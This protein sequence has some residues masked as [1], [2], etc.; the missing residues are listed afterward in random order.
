[1][2]DTTHPSGNWLPTETWFE[3]ATRAAAIG[4]WEWD[5]LS[6][7]MRYSSVAR[8]ICGFERHE[9]ITYEMVR[10]VTH[11]DD[12]PWT[13]ERARRALDPAIRD[14]PEYEY[15]IVQRG[16]GA[17]RWV[18]ARGEAMF[19]TV[20]GAERATRYVG[21]IQD[22]TEERAIAQ[23]LADSEARLRLAVE[24]AGMAV[25]E[26]D[27]IRGTLTRSPELNRLFGF[28]EDAEPTLDEF[29]SRYAPGE[30]QRIEAESAEVIA[31]G[32]DRIQTVIKLLWPDGTP[33]WLL[34]LAQAVP[35]TDLAERRAIGVVM[36]VTRQKLQEERLETVAHEMHHRIKNLIAIVGAIASQSL[37]GAPDTET[38]LDVLRGRLKALSLATD[39]I[40]IRGHAAGDLSTL[41]EAVIEPFRFGEAGR[42]VV[43]GDPAEVPL[44]A[45]QGIAMALHELCTNAVKYGALSA[46]E[47]H[48]EIAWERGE[49]ALTLVW[50]ERDGTGPAEGS[51]GYG[52]RLLRGLFA[53][54][55]ELALEFRPDGVECRIRVGLA[56]AAGV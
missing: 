9:E 44:R 24:A 29:R 22:I 1:M 30:R 47:G 13:S 21:T 20:G 3:I 16:T 48:I 25:W 35:G 23:R 11:P 4:V 36:D 8:R 37:K 26:V 55:D 51:A 39:A 41:V 6:G 14:L 7:K 40:L 54:P 53:S 19:E 31:R 2:P 12:Y 38:A 32:G 28:A 45:M 5:I 18:F 10:D 52:T 42:F 50:R 46:R 34:M 15:R 56:G 27:G 49:D 33:H 43:R 17:V